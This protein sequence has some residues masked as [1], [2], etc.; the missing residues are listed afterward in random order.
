MANAFD[1]DPNW[2]LIFELENVTVSI[3][4]GPLL[5]L[6]L[7]WNSYD[8]YLAEMTDLFGKVFSLA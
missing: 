3:C 8:V 5:F 2:D 6:A 7:G 4:A 1:N